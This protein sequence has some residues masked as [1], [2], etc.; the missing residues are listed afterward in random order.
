MKSNTEI[1]MQNEQAILNALIAENITSAQ[2]LKKSTD[3]KHWLTMVF[4]AN[5]D[6]GAVRVNDSSLKRV[7]YTPLNVLHSEEHQL[8]FKCLLENVYVNNFTWAQAMVAHSEV[9]TDSPLIR[10]CREQAT[11]IFEYKISIIYDSLNKIVY[12]MTNVEF[13]EKKSIEV[14][15]NRW[16][17]KRQS[18]SSPTTF[19]NQRC[20]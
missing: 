11:R 2:M 10:K 16:T 14:V 6:Y 7:S 17:V 20:R 1:T 18:E 13:L 19:R 9:I 15:P 5:G 8:E 12:S 4:Y 3:D